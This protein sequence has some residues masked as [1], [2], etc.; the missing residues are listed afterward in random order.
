MAPG[1]TFVFIGHD[2]SNLT[3]GVGGPSNPELLCTAD[4]IAA[5][6]PGVE[7]EKATIILR[8]VDGEE[9]D[10]VD[11]LVRARRRAPS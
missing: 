3:H 1:A 10:A 4:E 6:L 9:R 11:T 7:I 8:D 2:R 5:E